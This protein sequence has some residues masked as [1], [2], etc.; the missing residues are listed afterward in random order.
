MNR[1]VTPAFHC[2]YVISWNSFLEA[3]KSIKCATNDPI[4]L[5]FDKTA[6]RVDILQKCI[7]FFLCNKSLYI[8]QIRDREICVIEIAKKY[9]EF[10]K[11]IIKISH[12]FLFS[13]KAQNSISKF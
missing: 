5:M 3:N 4:N 13:L 7:H 11:C 12:L 2:Q 6:Y 1:N 8:R 9:C 10:E